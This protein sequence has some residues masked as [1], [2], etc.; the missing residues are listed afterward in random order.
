MKALMLILSLLELI[1]C[2]KYY[3]YQISSRSKTRANQMNRFSKEAE[4][5]TVRFV[6]EEKTPI[7]DISDEKTDGIVL[8][9]GK[10]AK[11]HD[12]DKVF[13]LMMYY[14]L[15]TIMIFLLVIFC[16]IPEI[17]NIILYVA[18]TLWR[19]IKYVYKV[20]VSVLKRE[21]QSREGWLLRKRKCPIIPL[22]KRKIKNER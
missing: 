14:F 7:V 10:S 12:F 18:I 17:R 22:V 9:K 1:L 8:E 16:M 20:L 3:L 5:V 21:W 6:N 2:E 4:S 11:E 13:N 19:P 15:P